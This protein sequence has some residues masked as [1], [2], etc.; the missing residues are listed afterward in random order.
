MA[1]EVLKSPAH[2]I[3]YPK[4]VVVNLWRMGPLIDKL[5]FWSYAPYRRSVREIR[6]ALSAFSRQIGVAP[7]VV[8]ARAPE[9]G[10]RL[11]RFGAALMVAGTILVVPAFPFLS[12]LD[13]SWE[14]L[15]SQPVS[16]PGGLQVDIPIAL[17]IVGI[18]LIGL[19]LFYVGK[20]MRERGQKLLQPTAD[21]L[22]VVDKRRPI[23]YLRSF[24][25]DV[26]ETS[27]QRG[28]PDIDSV[29][30]KS[31]EKRVRFETVLA[32]RLIKWGPVVAIGRPKEA[33][34]LLG[35]SRK[36]FSD[37]DWQTGISK[38]MDQ[39]RL[40][41][42]M[43]GATPGLRWELKEI[44]KAG[45]ASKLVVLFPPHVRVIHER[46]VELRKEV[47]N[48]VCGGLTDSLGPVPSVNLKY[49]IAMH[50][51]PD[52]GLVVM[53]GSTF[54]GY[55]YEQ[56]LALSVYGIFLHDWGASSAS[57]LPEQRRP[58]QHSRTQ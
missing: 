57:S 14:R 27:T 43:A 52:G 47:W 7:K 26:L 12:D 6:S 9:R 20:R 41:V 33:E 30:S 32:D 17:P 45:H 55:D 31:W 4:V 21:E 37:K 1:S 58:D 8:S 50:V 51:R 23:V 5:L 25:H 15:G 56:A 16:L 48:E 11:A 46:D 22:L 34:T 40:I 10:R 3:V 2:T 35:A 18:G 29:M 13:M 44:I 39:A 24:S 42:L 53:H 19:L 54:Q 38:W 36:Y 49:A 28:F